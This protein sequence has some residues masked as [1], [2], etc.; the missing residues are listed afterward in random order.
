MIFR[1]VLVLLLSTSITV[2]PA[3]A[4]SQGAKTGS[5]KESIGVA[6]EGSVS[7]TTINNTVTR[8][9]PA[10]LAA[11]AKTFADQMAASTE[12]RALA[13]AKAAELATQLGFTSAALTEFFR[14]LGE[15][16][17]PPEQMPKRLIEIATNYKQNTATLYQPLWLRYWG[18]IKLA[19]VWIQLSMA[20]A[21]LIMLW[22]SFLL[23][24]W[25]LAPRL[26]VKLYEKLPGQKI[27]DEL[28]D[29]TAKPT[30]GFR[31]SCGSLAA[32]R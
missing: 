30:M 17:V 3:V 22:S 9:D 10:V 19:P 13:E 12:A 28:A 18:R 1:L 27:I 32:P 29:L 26:L 20:L 5:D 15:Q 14:I 16:N 4:Q 2:L 31:S 7:N 25:V 8:Q 11:M 6:V 24:I 21:L 23:G